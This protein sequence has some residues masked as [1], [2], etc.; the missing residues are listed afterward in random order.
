MCVVSVVVWCCCLYETMSSRESMSM[1]FSYFI[2]VE[3][4]ESLNVA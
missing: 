2:I 4:F 1:S 3:S